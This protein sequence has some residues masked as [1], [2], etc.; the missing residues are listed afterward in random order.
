[1][2]NLQDIWD[3]YKDRLKKS[4][5]DGNFDAW[6][7]LWADDKPTSDKPTFVVKYGEQGED[8]FKEEVLE[9]RDKIVSL[10]S[11]SI[12]KIEIRFEDN[13]PVYVTQNKSDTFLVISDFIATIIKSGY[14]YKN[15]ILC[16]V[17]LDEQR[18]IKKLI[19]YA[20]PIKRQNFLK[21]LKQA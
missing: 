5:E 13:G 8:G 21:E 6:C 20:D 17:T 9:G 12:G 10:F 3:S 2:S 15:R 11:N 18:K 16:Q 14:P 7:D 19:E 1:M 4:Y